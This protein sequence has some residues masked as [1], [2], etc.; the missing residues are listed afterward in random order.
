MDFA[1]RDLFGH[2]VGVAGLAADVYEDAA[3]LDSPA[4]VI[5]C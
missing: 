5:S 2:A 4:V 1:Q 3:H